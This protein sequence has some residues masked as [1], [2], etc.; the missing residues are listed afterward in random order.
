MRALAAP[1][2]LGNY[3]SIAPLYRPADHIQGNISAADHDVV[4]QTQNAISVRAEPCVPKGV[5]TFLLFAVMR[6]P[7][8]FDDEAMVDAKKVDDIA[9]DGDLP[10]KFQPVQFGA[11]QSPPEYRLGLGH[12]A[13]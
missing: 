7:V 4:A 1:T 6:R 10:A 5:V 11:A 3:I 13:S 9:A 8:E 2:G 12:L